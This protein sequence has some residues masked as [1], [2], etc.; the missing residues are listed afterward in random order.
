MRSIIGRFGALGVLPMVLAGLLVSQSQAADPSGAAK[1]Y[2]AGG[3]FWCMEEVFEKVPGVTAVVSGY[4]GGRVEHPSYEQVSAGGTGH[5]ESVEVV[6]DPT[7]ASYTTLLDA[8]WHNV[9]PVT[10]NAQFC[11]HGSQYRS[12]I[13]YQGEEQKRLAEESKRAIEQSQRLTQPIVTELTKASQFYPAEEYHQDFYKKNPIR[14]KFYKFN[15]GRAQR[16]EEVWGA[17]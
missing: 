4:M 6:Y 3:C 16:L 12:V 15:C 10:P 1:A 13:F 11:D 17:P 5:A 8:F 14:Y 9:D 7:K 2:F